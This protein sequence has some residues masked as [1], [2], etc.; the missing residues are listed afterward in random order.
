MPYETSFYVT[1]VSNGGVKGE[2]PNNTAASF[3]N[4]LPQPLLLKGKWN[5]GLA[6]IYLPGTEN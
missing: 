6:S 4:R 1:L 3:K 5:V 2:Y